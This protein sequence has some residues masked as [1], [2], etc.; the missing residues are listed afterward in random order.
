MEEIKCIFCKNSDSN[1]FIEE[2]G[3]TGRKCSRCGLIY[4]SPRPKQSEIKLIYTHDKA[5]IKAKTHIAA[6]SSRFNRLHEK[7]ALKII[8]KYI[9]KGALLEIGCGGGSFLFA[10]QKCGFQ[11]FGIELNPQQ[12]QYVRENGISCEG[13]PLNVNSFQKKM[14]D[15]IYH[16]NVI[17]HFY[18]PIADF[19]QIYDHLN[20]GGFLV[21]ET[22]N[23]GDVKENYFGIIK[24]TEKF[25]FPDHLYFFGQNNIKTLL[26]LTGFKF[27]KAHGYSR[28]PEKYVQYGLKKWRFR[29]PFTFQNLHYFLTYK[30]GY[31]FPKKGMPQTVIYIAKK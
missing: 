9:E 3:Y 23:F 19:K 17:S 30:L 24:E 6:R 14:F 5:N 2:N 29:H 12:V 10:S 8:K 15:I 13:E 25:Q 1:V 28:I 11:P 21:F 16:C 31:L 22:G 20:D 7:H 18:D 4:V 26:D 27:I